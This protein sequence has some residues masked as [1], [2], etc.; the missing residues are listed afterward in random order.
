MVYS[1]LQ[2]IELLIEERL[3]RQP[4]APLS[5]TIRKQQDLIKERLHANHEIGAVVDLNF[6]TIRR[7]SSRI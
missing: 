7:V 1:N 2:I 3:H 6:R 4:S 5:L